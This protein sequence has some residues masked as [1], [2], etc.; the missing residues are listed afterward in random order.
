MTVAELIK[1]LQV[2]NPE[3][4]V[5]IHCDGADRIDNFGVYVSRSGYVVLAESPS[6][7]Y[8]DKR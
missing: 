6:D 8:Y 7:I 3:F 5:H 2:L 4:E 1:K